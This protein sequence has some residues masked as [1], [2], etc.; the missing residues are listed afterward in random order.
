[1]ET[2]NERIAWCVKDSNLTKTAF[3][4]K[5]NV[6]Q[7]FISRLVSGEK[8]PSDRTI[9]DI[10]REFNISELWLRTGEG[11]PHIQRDE[12]E[13]F[14]EVMEQIHMSDDDLI[15]RIIKAYWFMEDDEKAAI[16]K[17]IDGFTKK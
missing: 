1:M 16:R 14:L 2:I 11:E 12:D 7:S 13:E 10:C 17:L 5:I 4:E 8:V 3:A 9:A 15:K 6:S